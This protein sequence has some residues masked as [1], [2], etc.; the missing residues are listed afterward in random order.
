M[1]GA[2]AVAPVAGGDHCHRQQV[3]NARDRPGAVLAAN[4]GVVQVV[5]SV[6]GK[7][8]AGSLHDN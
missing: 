5:V 7:L 3:G 4:Q 6:H 2:A 1:P 8:L